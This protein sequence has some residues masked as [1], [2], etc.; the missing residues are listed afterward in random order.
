MNGISITLA[1]MLTAHCKLYE[2]RLQYCRLIH[3]QS[4]IKTDA[5]RK[6]YPNGAKIGRNKIAIQ[7]LI[8]GFSGLALTRRFEV[9]PSVRF[10]SKRSKIAKLDL[11]NPETVLDTFSYVPERLLMKRD[12]VI[13]VVRK[14]FDKR[15]GNEYKCLQRETGKY[16]AKI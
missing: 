12:L 16:P 6:S 14:M 3:L 7:L 13:Q 4:D 5:P 9:C 10:I 1:A 2:F 8:Q 15:E 11:Q